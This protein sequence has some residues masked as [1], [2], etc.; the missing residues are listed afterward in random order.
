MTSLLRIFTIFA[1]FCL[2]TLGCGSSEP[3]VIQ[4]LPN[5][6]EL[7]TLNDSMAEASNEDTEE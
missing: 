5:D 2:P 7:Q 6:A 3:T 1:L 4:P